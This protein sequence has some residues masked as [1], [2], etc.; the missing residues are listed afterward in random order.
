MALLA[1]HLL[2]VSPGGRQARRESDKGPSTTY[3]TELKLLRRE[4][5]GGGWSVG[6][7]SGGLLA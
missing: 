2:S 3:M 7:G 5:F 6:Q 1:A 4:V